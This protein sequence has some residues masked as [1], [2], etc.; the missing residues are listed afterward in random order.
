[1]NAEAITAV[2]AAVVALV[3]VSKWSGIPDRWGPVVVLILSAVGVAIWAYSQSA[4]P[5]RTELFGYFAGWIVVAAAAAGVFGFTR[6]GAEA[7][8]RTKSPPA[9]GAG[10]SPTN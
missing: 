6:A 4:L 1:M 8:T 2:S 9:G 10:G 7:V 3:Q 5:M